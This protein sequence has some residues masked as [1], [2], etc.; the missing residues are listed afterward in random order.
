MTMEN[1]IIL[2][3]T[4][5]TENLIS[6]SKIQTKTAIIIEKPL[7]MTINDQSVT[8]LNRASNT[9]ILKQNKQS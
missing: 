7:T 6:A 5:K 4:I 2:T 1:I 9:K 3:F 8:A